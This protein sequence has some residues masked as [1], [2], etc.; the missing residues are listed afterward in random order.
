GAPRRAPSGSRARRR[1][2]GTRGDDP[3]R[4]GGRERVV[5]ERGVAAAQRN[6]G[7]GPGAR[8]RGGGPM[9]DENGELENPTAEEVAEAPRPAGGVVREAAGCVVALAVVFGFLLLVLWGL[10]AFLGTAG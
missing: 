9:T 8:H 10:R 4:A 7:A 2:A 5:G 1:D 3:R 6:A